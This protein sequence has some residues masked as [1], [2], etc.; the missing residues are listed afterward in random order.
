MCNDAK[1]PFF[2]TNKEDNKN[3]LDPLVEKNH[4]PESA[5]HMHLSDGE[6]EYCK[7]MKIINPLM[8]PKSYPLY[9]CVAPVAKGYNFL[10]HDIRDFVE[11]DP[12]RDDMCLEINI[13]ASIENGYKWEATVTFYNNDVAYPLVY[14]ERD[15]EAAKRRMEEIFRNELDS[16]LESFDKNVSNFDHMLAFDLI[17]KYIALGYDYVLL[18]K[19]YS[20]MYQYIV[21]NIRESHIKS[22]KQCLD[23]EKTVL[24]NIA[25]QKAKLESQFNDIRRIETYLSIIYR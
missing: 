9:L 24:E 15:I 8:E 20:Q 13:K 2:N 1:M 7:F 14:V 22:A 17:C 3:I 25:K 16:H 10:Y 19:K 5:N 6:K 11:Y 12:S 21:K 4:K 23:N 18:D